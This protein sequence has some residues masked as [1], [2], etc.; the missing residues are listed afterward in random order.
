MA[1]GFMEMSISWNRLSM[2]TKGCSVH[3]PIV[4]INFKVSSIGQ[5]RL[6]PQ[7]ATGQGGK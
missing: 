3:M 5:D 1:C 2:S 4:I 7:V 6:L